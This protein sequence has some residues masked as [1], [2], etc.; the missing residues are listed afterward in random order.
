M[1]QKKSLV[2]NLELPKLAAQ[3]TIFFNS[4]EFSLSPIYGGASTRRYY[5]LKFTQLQY[6]V[7]PEVVLMVVSP[8]NISV[9]DNYLKIGDYLTKYRI[10]HPSIFEVN[11]SR[12][13]IFLAHG[14]GELL[15][16]YL[17]TNPAEKDMLYSR[18][19][20]FL[21]ALQNQAKIEKSCP[22]FQRFFDKE[23]FLY[24][25]RFH[26]R[27]QLIE[28]YFN[29]RLSAEEIAVYE[30]FTE[31]ISETLS[32]TTS[33][34]VHRDFQSSNIFYDQRNRKNPFQIIDF[35]D[36]R[37]GSPLYDLVSLLWDS[38]FEL[39]KDLQDKLI[40]KFYQAQPRIS[41]IYDW[42]SYRRLI[43]LTM[44]Q[45]KLHDAGAF[46]YS[47]QSQRKVTFRQYIPAAMN[48][49]LFALEQLPEYDGFRNFFRKILQK[50]VNR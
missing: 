26:V 47:W 45:R 41:E 23:K 3:L 44:F 37:S 13:W 39:G 20:E 16:T 48:M 40:R 1:R 21:I 31:K 34:F 18:L 42:E 11:R 2:E 25:F 9:L 27:E 32:T 5:K 35:Q 50:N 22:A 49:A 7:Q 38:Y 30:K 46:A 15:L 29:Y 6:F 10:N 14:S 19:I 24:E 28:N 17:K 12:G 43:F 33:V 8:D 4:S 36:A